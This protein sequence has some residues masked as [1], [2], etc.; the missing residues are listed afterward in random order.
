MLPDRRAEGGGLLRLV[1]GSVYEQHG[2][3]RRESEHDRCRMELRRKS[4]DA[5]SG[6]PA[7]G[8]D[9]SRL[10]LHQFMTVK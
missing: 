7:R 9:A 6:Q 8:R 4:G 3:A 1:S 2:S 10:R 5:L